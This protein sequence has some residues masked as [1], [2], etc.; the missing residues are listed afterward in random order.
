MGKPFG[1]CLECGCER[2][3]LLRDRRCLHLRISQGRDWLQG[4]LISSIHHADRTSAR[5]VPVTNAAVSVYGNMCSAAL[6][7]PPGRWLTRVGA[8]GWQQGQATCWGT[9]VCWGIPAAWGIRHTGSPSLE[10]S[11]SAQH[12]AAGAAQAG[13]WLKESLD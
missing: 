1:I 11:P 9:G 13:G 4:C 12:R 8:V 3:H 2:S 5:S 7:N 6:R 10:T